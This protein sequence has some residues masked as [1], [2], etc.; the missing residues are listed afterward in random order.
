MPHDP[1]AFDLL[2]RG[3][4]VI[5]GTRAPRFAADVGIRAGRIAEIGDLSARA[6]HQVLDASG[7]I[8]AP[9][10]ID[11][12]THDDQALLSQAQMPFKVSQGV[13]TVVTG[14]CGI[15]AAPLRAGM[16]LPMPLSLLDTPAEG[17]HTRFAAYLDAL[18][19]APASVNVAALV[20]HSTLRA[21][22]MA[23]LDRPANAAEIGAMQELVEEALQAGAIGLSSGTFYPPAAQA[24]TEEI[25]AVGRPLTA[26]KALYATHMRDEADQVMEALQ[27]SF[28]IG[29]ALDVAVVISHHKV[30][31]ARNFGKTRLTLPFIQEAM[32]HQCIA[33]DCYPYTAGSTMIRT[34]RGMLD[35]RVLIASSLAHPECA[36]RDLKD[37][38]AEWGVSGT[39]A[40][41]RLQ[42]GSAIYFMMHED[43]VQRILAFDE[44]MIGSDGI[45]LGEKPHPRLWGSF[46][47]VLGHY[48]RDLGLFP[49]ETAVWKM[50]GLTARNF[51]LQGRGTLAPGQHADVVIFDAATVRDRAS[52]ENP[53]QAA[54]G[55]D[56]VI[57]NGAVTWQ[58]GAHSGAR[59]GQVIVRKTGK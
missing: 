18:R 49:L 43:D 25:I 32:R 6:A 56:T 45:P 42:P 29:R 59:N 13:T 22:T 8:V 11:A 10:F 40:A 28:A 41:R 47:R 38:A 33:L 20:G 27:E 4:D 35:C 46:P 21:V 50:S 44:T 31:N 17:R 36:G 26:R 55:I 48:S 1:S 2:I 5:D 52:Y 12:H 30:Q 54:E 9:G 51:G 3:G 34:D 15:S 16:D 37:I 57:V 14:N 24:T 7:R 53:T 39:E 23:D 58:N 19:A